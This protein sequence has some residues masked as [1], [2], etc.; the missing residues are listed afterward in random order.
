M[1]AQGS[2]HFISIDSTLGHEVVPTAAVHS[3]T[4]YAVRAISEVFRK[5]NSDIRVCIVS[6]SF[7][8]SELI[9]G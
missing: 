2:G 5:E 1:K 8:E 9:Q 7:V 4:K 6:P 3:T